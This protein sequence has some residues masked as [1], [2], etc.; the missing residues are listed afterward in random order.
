[1]WS[2]GNTTPLLFGMQTC[3]TTLEISMVVSQ[4]LGISLLQDPAIPFLGIYSKDIQLYYKVICSA[5]FMAALFIIAR[6]WKQPRFP[7]TEEM[8]K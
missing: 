2:K 8:N 7:P 3:T 4:K 1:M 5:M 6:T